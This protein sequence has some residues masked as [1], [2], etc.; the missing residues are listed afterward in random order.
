MSKYRFAC[1]EWGMP[2]NGSYSVRIAAEAGL[3][4]LQIEIG[5]YEDGYPLAQKSVREGYMEDAK[6][7]GIEFPN[8]TVNDVGTYEFVNGRNTPNGRIAYEAF[9]IAIECAA[10]MGIDMVLIPNFFDNFITKPEHY[11]NVAEALQYCC[12][13]GKRYG[14]TIAHETPLLW[15]DHKK[16]FDKVNRENIGVFYDSMNYKFWINADPMQ[17][18]KD[19]YPY[20]VNQ[21][22]FKDGVTE[23]S[24]ALLGEGS[25]EFAEQAKFIKESDYSGWIITENFY[26]HLPIR[27]SSTADQIALLKKDLRTMKAALGAN[28]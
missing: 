26:S 19:V 1:T 5:K 21:L 11:D 12:D 10:E 6:R 8:V 20:M 22:H 28:E 27:G 7:Y 16:I 18:L 24:T 3:D 2:G 4:G 17:V 13:K 25:M 9:D 15:K 14:I 23:M